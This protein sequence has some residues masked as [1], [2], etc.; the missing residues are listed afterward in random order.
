MALAPEAAHRL[1][2]TALKLGL[3]PRRQSGDDPVLATRVWGRTFA[4]PI[5]LAAGFDK[6]GEVIGAMA[7][8]GFGFVE[9]GTVTPKPQ[10]GNPKPRMVRWPARQG[11]INRLGFNN[12]GL[13]SAA[14][15]LA[16][17]P[18]GV[19]VGAN[20]GRNK[21]QSDAIADY[22]AGTERLAGLADYLVVNISSP[23]TAGLR[24][25][26]EGRALADLLTAVVAARDGTGSATPLVVKIAPDLDDAA[27]DAL[28]AAVL[29]A[30][31]D[32][33]AVSNTTISRPADMPERLA[34]EAGGLSGPPLFALSTDRLRHV[35]RRVA[36]RVPLIG[37]GGV[38][39]GQDAYAKIRAGASLVQL[40]TALAYQ[41][42]AL[43]PAIKRDLAAALR[44]D[45][46]ASLNEA[47]GRDVDSLAGSA[48][49]AARTGGTT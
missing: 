35:A 25:L 23:N 46:F 44:A 3:G 43:V 4:N 6:D 39:S 8:L 34:R 27:L 24:D 11:L 26:Q 14:V 37:I 21:D 20:I 28:V 18:G 17:R 48:L 5:G 9:V 45:G 29:D 16:R 30:G 40:Y 32:G 10:P 33:I 22:V 1:T 36:G 19:I 38:A 7:R 47:V 2:V 42:P 13:D 31:I 49:P 15:R 12:H 41:G